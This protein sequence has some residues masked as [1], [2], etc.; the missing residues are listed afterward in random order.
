[1]PV[2]VGTLSP[3]KSYREVRVF[4]GLIKS[5]RSSDLSFERTGRLESILVDESDLVKKGQSLAKIDSRNLVAKRNEALAGAKQAQAVLDELIAGPRQETKQAAQA[6]VDALEAELKQ[7]NFDLKRRA[8]LREK[9]SISPEE[10]ERTKTRQQTTQARLNEAKQNLKELESGTRNEKIAS[11]RAVVE[12]AKATVADLDVAIE[13][14]TLKAP[15]AGQI[16]RRF[17][18]EGAMIAPGASVLR[19]VEHEVLEARIG[20]PPAV[21]PELT[22][23]GEYS[24]TISGRSVLSRLSHVLPEVDSR[25]RTR[26]AIFRIEADQPK[27]N[28]DGGAANDREAKRESPFAPGSI[29]KI[30]LVTETPI[31]GYWVPMEALTPGAR[32][33]WAVLVAE[34]RD[35][36]AIAVRREVE[37]IR[38]QTDRAIIRGTIRPGDQVILTGTHCVAPGG[39]VTPLVDETSRTQ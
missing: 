19:M 16:S 17:L 4:T 22:V 11:Q 23:G 8:R 25:T 38:T 3:V 33:L 9:K 10:Y 26:M 13:K 14:S 2:K 35:G 29:A 15:Y 31:E 27:P 12:R 20:L 6:R 30:E 32:G 21:V 18:D 7:A 37:L 36:Q 34:P 24:L 1:M 5:A 39:H 28:S